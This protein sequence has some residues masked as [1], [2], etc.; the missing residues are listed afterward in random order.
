MASAIDTS[1]FIEGVIILFVAFN[2]NDIEDFQNMLKKDGVGLKYRE[3]GKQLFENDKAK[4]KNTIE[5]YY[6]ES[7]ES[8][9]DGNKIMAEWFPLV[10]SEIFISH[11]HADIEVIYE[12]VGF[13]FVELGIKAFID[14]SVWGYAD[15][16]LKKIDDKHC[17]NKGSDVYDY[18][19]RN[20]TTSN[21]YL[22][23]LNSLQNMIDNT[24]CVLFVQTPNSVKKIPDQFEDS[25]YSPWIFSELN[26]VE[27][28]KV[29]KPI[30]YH[31]ENVQFEKRGKYKNILIE[32]VQVVYQIS[33]QISKIPTLSNT[34]LISWKKD[35][36]SNSLAENNLDILYLL[37]GIL[38]YE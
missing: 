13:L 3:K 16:L 24:E 23:L 37:K 17:K 22:M 28:I 35:V 29:K 4:I 7:E 32:N 8:L 34:D 33:E 15:E 31:K 6:L 26:I 19:K 2:F 21:V 18:H 27:K 36:V 5:S 38:Q 20:I 11:S 30:R 9:L 10:E 1:T 25:T 14:S 12:L